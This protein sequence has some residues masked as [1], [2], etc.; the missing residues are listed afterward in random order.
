MSGW[1]SDWGSWRPGTEDT[2]RGDFTACFG[3]RALR[4]TT[5]VQKECLSAHYFSTLAEARAII[6][7]WR[8]EYN[9][10]RP[11]RSLNG[12]TPSEF[13]QRHQKE[14]EGTQELNL[15]VV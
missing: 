14:S 8:I 12:L 15:Q 13:A 7:A 4:S 2:G 9:T 10:Y 11:H 3:E 5:S 1:G 6:E